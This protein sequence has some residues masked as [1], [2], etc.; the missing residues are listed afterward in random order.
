MTLSQIKR[1]YKKFIES[2]EKDNQGFGFENFYWCYLKE[3]YTTSYDT[4][5][6]HD[7]LDIIESELKE[8]KEGK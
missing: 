6:I 5:T 2:I 1:K 7:T 4:T 8:I 3:P